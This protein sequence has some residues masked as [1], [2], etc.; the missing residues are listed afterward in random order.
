MRRMQLGVVGHIPYEVVPIA[1]LYAVLPSPAQ[2]RM[3]LAR[4]KVRQ[5]IGTHAEGNWMQQK[6]IFS[7][8]SRRRIGVDFE[9]DFDD[10]PVRNLPQKRVV[11]FN[12]HQML[13]GVGLQKGRLDPALER[14]FF[15]F[16]PYLESE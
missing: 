3:H 12:H 16:K 13:N 14:F 8:K 2:D 10:L 6:L 11:R 7:C 5:N 1:P 15:L 9:T 4:K